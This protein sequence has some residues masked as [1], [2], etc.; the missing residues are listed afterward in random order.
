LIL[1]V[2]NRTD[3]HAHRIYFAA[4]PRTNKPDP[5]LLPIH[6]P[7]CPDCQ[8]RMLTAA[9]LPGP[10]G[11][12]HRIFECARCAHSETRMVARDPLDSNALS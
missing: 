4:M 2:S 5:E 3:I 11:F 12:E 10:E 6:R 1:L 7:R 9:V 8:A